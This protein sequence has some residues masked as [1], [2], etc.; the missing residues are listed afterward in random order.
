MDVD[1]MQRAVGAE[2]RNDR[3]DLSLHSRGEFRLVASAYEN[4][5]VPAPERADFTANEL[6][7]TGLRVND[8]DAGLRNED[9]DAGRDVGNSSSHLDQRSALRRLSSS[10]RSTALLLSAIARLYARS[11]PAASPA[12]LSS[13]AWAACSG[14]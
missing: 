8:P 9:V 5:V 6:A 7:F 3:I 10:A 13:S 2:G 4:L 12:R 14:W 1:S 11:A